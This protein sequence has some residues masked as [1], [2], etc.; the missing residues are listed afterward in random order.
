MNPLYFH[1]QLIADGLARVSHDKVIGEFRPWLNELVVTALT[2]ISVKKN[3]RIYMC[4][5][6]VIKE[7]IVINVTCKI[8]ERWQTHFA[9]IFA[10]FRGGALWL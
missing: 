6:E 5:K 9:Y 1:C 8:R 4:T 10:F 2:G 7:K 3:L